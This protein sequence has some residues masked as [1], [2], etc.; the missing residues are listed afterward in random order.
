MLIVAS[1][2]GVETNAL[3]PTRGIYLLPAPTTIGLLN[4]SNALKVLEIELPII[5]TQ[6]VSTDMKVS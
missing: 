4:A 3:V 5:S 2:S 6:G 1:Q